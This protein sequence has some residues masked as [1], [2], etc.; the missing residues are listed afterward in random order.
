MEQGEKT[1]KNASEYK[2]L[3]EGDVRK[4]LKCCRGTLIEMTASGRFP[5]PIR[6]GVKKYWRDEVVAAW[7][8]QQ[9][10]L[11]GRNAA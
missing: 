9:Q 8:E 4:I 11:P 2:L 7:L 1:M 5:Q 10:P 6:V 3:N